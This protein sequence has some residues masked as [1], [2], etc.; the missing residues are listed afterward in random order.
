MTNLQDWGL[1]EMVQ[2]GAAARLAPGP[3]HPMEDCVHAFDRWFV[4][5]L[6]ERLVA[7]RR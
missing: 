7:L 1:C 4:E 3:Y 2:I 5:Q 6:G